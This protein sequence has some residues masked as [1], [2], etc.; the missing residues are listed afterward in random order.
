MAS[1][2]LE[3]ENEFLRAR[4]AE[5]I[6]HIKGLVSRNAEH[7]KHIKGLVFEGEAIFHRAT[8]LQERSD[9]L[10]S[11]KD[12]AL[13]DLERQEEYADGLEKTLAKLRSKLEETTRRNVLWMRAGKDKIDKLESQLQDEANAGNCADKIEG[14]EGELHL[15]AEALEVGKLNY[16]KISGKLHAATNALARWEAAAESMRMRLDKSDHDIIDANDQ[17]VEANKRTHQSE[18]LATKNRSWAEDRVRATELTASATRRAIEME[19]TLGINK[20]HM[21]GWTDITG[22]SAQTNTNSTD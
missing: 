16:E 17:I 8:E 3:E 11:V 18:L 22:Y 4:N 7:M 21:G 5:H 9:S 10:E 6:K 12:D 2:N 20:T 15:A 14:L 13:D 19:K 1:I